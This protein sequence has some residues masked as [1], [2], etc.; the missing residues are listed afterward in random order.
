MNILDEFTLFYKDYEDYDSN[1]LEYYLT[2]FYEQFY[3]PLKESNLNEI[4]KVILTKTNK[5]K[6]D[7]FV[8]YVTKY[9]IKLDNIFIIIY[10]TVY[11]NIVFKNLKQNIQIKSYL[12]QDELT[13]LTLNNEKLCKLLEYLTKYKSDSCEYNLWI[14]QHY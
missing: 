11:K 7:Q 12:N 14:N 10:N 9:N 6:N 1:L 5:Q 13:K 2:K 4:N 8:S 3:K